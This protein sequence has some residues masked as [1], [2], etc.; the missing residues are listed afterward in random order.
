M[1]QWEWGYF[2]KCSAP[3]K[4]GFTGEIIRLTRGGCYWKAPWLTLTRIRRSSFLHASTSVFQAKREPEK[5]YTE[6]NKMQ[7]VHQEGTGRSVP[8]WEQ[9]TGLEP[10]GLGELLPAPAF[11]HPPHRPPRSTSRK[12]D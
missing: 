5:F 3:E 7:W 6:K 4:R 10:Q 12:H 11:V 9:S 1:P 2:V 8:P